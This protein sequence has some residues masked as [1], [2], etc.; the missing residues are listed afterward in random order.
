MDHQDWNPVVL[1]KNIPNATRN[2]E[3]VVYI[4]N[5]NNN[6]Q[7]TGK[8]IVDEDGEVKKI[9]NVGIVI[10]TQISQAR[11]AKKISQKDLA[12]QM[13]LPLQL[14]QQTENGKAVRNNGLLA[15]LERK[16]GV[17]FNR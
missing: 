4:S 3:K 2:T 8:K 11:S 7:S 13:N 12:T 1:K 15:K 14:I 10:G 17:K 5:T 9:P 16:L 6:Y